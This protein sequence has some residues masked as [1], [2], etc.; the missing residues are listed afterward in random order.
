MNYTVCIINYYQCHYHYHIIII[1]LLN[2]HYYYYLLP[3]VCYC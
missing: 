3:V 2:Y 1:L